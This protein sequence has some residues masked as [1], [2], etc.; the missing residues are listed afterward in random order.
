[1]LGRE[2]H[3]GSLAAEEPNA[4]FVQ[5]QRFEQVGGFEDVEAPGG[6]GGGL[7]GFGG[8]VVFEDDGGVGDGVGFRGE[9]AG[10]GV[11][12]LLFLG[13]VDGVGIGVFAVRCLL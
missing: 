5:G 4:A 2:I 8:F 9:G 13:F 10:G 3:D 11:V 1:M 7:A 6:G 12:G